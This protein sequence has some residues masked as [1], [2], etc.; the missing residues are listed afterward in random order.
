VGVKLRDHLHMI[1]L[2]RLDRTTHVSVPAWTQRNQHECTSVRLGHINV[3]GIRKNPF[4]EVLQVRKLSVRI[5]D[6]ASKSFKSQSM[7]PLSAI[8]KHVTESE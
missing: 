1:D 8:S 6:L 5:T 7:R 3:L 2:Q 4:H